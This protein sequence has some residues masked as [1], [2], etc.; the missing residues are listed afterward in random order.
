M[1]EPRTQ[2]KTMRASHDLIVNMTGRCV[3]LL[4]R[5]LESDNAPDI[6]LSIPH[7]TFEGYLGDFSHSQAV[8]SKVG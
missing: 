4:A 7:T 2:V 6:F 8:G 3:F 1:M 5:R